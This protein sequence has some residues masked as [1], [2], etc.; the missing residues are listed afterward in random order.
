MDVIGSAPEA[1]APVGRDAPDVL[2]TSEDRRRWP[3]LA[4]VAVLL[5]AGVVTALDGSTRHRELDDLLA[6]V[7]VGRS[8]V[9]YADRRIAAAITYGTPVLYGSDARPGLRDDVE[10]IVRDAADFAAP[11][12]RQALERV[13]ALRFRPWHG[14]L[15]RARG[16]YAVYLRAALDRLRAVH[17]D[18]GALFQR[19]PR[20]RELLLA[21]RRALLAA[22]P[23]ETA[24]I[25]D[26]L[27]GLPP[28]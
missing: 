11:G 24:R 28:S 13:E 9:V 23:A 10:L 8:S 7:D 12:V 25:D 26:A 18:Y 5:L 4:L 27:G 3:A 6:G 17:R 21:A 16:A 15:E 14:D 19:G 22:A 2:D 20:Q 1:G